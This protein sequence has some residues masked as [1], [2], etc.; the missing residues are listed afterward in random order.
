M[1]GSFD[2]YDHLSQRRKGAKVFRI[3]FILP[4]LSLRLRVF[5]SSNIIQV[6]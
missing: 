3:L 2:L 1:K 4:S 5:A 6:F